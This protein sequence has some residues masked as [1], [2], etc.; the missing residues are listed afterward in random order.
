MSY[1]SP[2]AVGFPWCGSPYHEARPVRT[3]G[4]DTAGGVDAAGGGDTSGRVGASG[5]GMVTEVGDVTQPA[6][7]STSAT[8]TTREWSI[9][10][11]KVSIA[12]PTGREFA[13]LTEHT[14]FLG[15]TL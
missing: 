10:R 12:M 13:R 5:G 8:P 2:L 3:S 15:S 14:D 1:T 6:T 4:D 7:A 9:E 11:L